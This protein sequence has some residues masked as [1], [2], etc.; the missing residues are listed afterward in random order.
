MRAPTSGGVPAGTQVGP[1]TIEGLLGRGG[2]GAV[3]R[4]TG[5]DGRAVALKLLSRDATKDPRFVTRF[6]R[7]G[8]VAARIEHPHI[9][10]CF[11]IGEAQGN[12]WLAMELLPGGSL[13]DL[14]KKGA[15]PWREAVLRGAEIARALEA[16][17]RE[18]IVHRDLKPANVLLDGAG[19]TKLCDFGLARTGSSDLTRT[20][21]FMGTLEYLAPELAD[22]AKTADERTDLYA[23][24]ATI[25]CL[26]TGVPP[27]QGTGAALIAQHVTQPAPLVT[28]RV[29]DVPAEVDRILQR[30]LAKDQEDRGTA[31][32]AGRELEAL[33][34]LNTSRARTPAILIGFVFVA[35][36]VAAAVALT[37]REDASAPPAPPPAPVATVSSAELLAAA[38]AWFRALDPKARPSLP[39]RRGLRIGDR[40][41]EYVSEKDG[42]VLVFVP[43]GKFLM[44]VGKGDRG[45]WDDA[46]PEH[47]V[48]LS[49]YFLGKYEV[50]T[51]QWRRY[52]KE[53][54]VVTDAERVGGQIYV[55]LHGD[56]VAEFQFD[57]TANWKV[58][59]GDGVPAKDNDPVVQ[60]TQI[61][62]QDYSTWA[63]LRLPTEAEW[64]RA[65]SWDRGSK[66][67]YAWGDD[68]PDASH[69]AVGDPMSMN[70]GR[71]SPVTAFER[72]P[73]PVG[74]LNMSG[75]AREWV[76]DT[77]R[78]TGK[79]GYGDDD[80]DPCRVVPGEDK[81][82]RGGS[83]AQSGEPLMTGYRRRY[84]SKQLIEGAARSDDTT[85]F[86][87][88]LSEDGSPRGPR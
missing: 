79:G 45:D 11:G 40:E 25:F 28:K 3:Y 26:I 46:K 51:L 13:Q 77:Y 59:Q 37:R 8:E 86:R 30:L 80:V 2:M 68:T 21:E 64:E 23:L 60:I 74:A 55:N 52:A 82:T 43:Q 71:L 29:P 7:E 57:K 19:R 18:G 34:T 70:K 27:F 31:A 5:A 76:L 35:A 87:L 61:E 41:R 4:A 50:S 44:G 58:P 73:S 22:G 20:N 24:G 1:W 33:A 16:L 83:F 69:G 17:H 54:N 32:E 47:E 14:V 6:M 78:G 10:R 63:N 38:P 84:W 88:A 42:T 67:V 36:G 75:N 62:A 85:G 49:A 72:W 65:A 12:L 56:S 53:N 15:L 39:L 9:T 48:L 81:I 66:R